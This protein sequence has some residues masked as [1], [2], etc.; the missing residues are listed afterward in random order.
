M[1]PQDF[2]RL[3]NNFYVSQGIDADLRRIKVD[4]DIINYCVSSERNPLPKY[5]V[6]FLCICLNEPYWPFIQPM[7]EGAKQFFLPGHKTDFFVWTDMPKNGTIPVLEKAIVDL[8]ILKKQEKNAYIDGLNDGVEKAIAILEKTTKESEKM[9][10]ATIFPTESMS[11]PLPTLFRYNLFLE[12]EN[13][14]KDYDYIF[15]CDVDMKFVGVVGDEILGQGLTAAQ[16]P[17]YALRKEY[18]PPYEPNEMST[19]FIKRPGRV[20]TDNGKPR[21]MPLYF[22]GGFQG[23]KSEMF[24]ASMKRMRDNIQKDYR[25]GYIPIWND[26]TQ[27]NYELFENPPDVVLTPAYIYPD[28]LIKEYYEPL[29]GCSYS[30][31]LMTLTKKFSTSSEGGAAVNKMLQETKSLQ[32]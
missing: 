19:S 23:G 9:F 14:L 20:I 18:W 10:G 7:I 1:N 21:F 2:I 12:Q 28:S 30:P 22:A 32:K 11:W 24:I 31:R 29:W 27:W 25:R 5:K 15:Y 26:E 6:A 8:N 13:I 4:S 3:A 17:M 16:H